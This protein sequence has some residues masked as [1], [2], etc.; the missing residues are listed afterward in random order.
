MPIVA[1]REPFAVG[2]YLIA[3][4]GA[5][6]NQFNA[7]LRLDTVIKSSNATTV[8]FANGG[9]P[10]LPTDATALLT[11]FAMTFSIPIT[12]NWTLYGKLV[13]KLV[14]IAP[15][16]TAGTPKGKLELDVK[17]NGVAIPSLLKATSGQEHNL[18]GS[19]SATFTEVFVVTFP[20]A[21]SL[22]AGTTLDLVLTPRI[23]TAS[24]SGGST[25]TLQLKT[26]PASAGSDSMVEFP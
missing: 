12:T 2:Y 3:A 5:T 20:A 18:N 23:T 25:C 17:N 19:P 11:A 9:S 4:D 24:G 15:T 22:V 21:V 1:G 26:N 13:A 8:A 14:W 10:N 16:S 6:G 7:A